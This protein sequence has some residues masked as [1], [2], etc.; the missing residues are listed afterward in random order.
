MSAKRV[1]N[2]ILPRMSQNALYSGLYLVESNQLVATEPYRDLLVTEHALR[3]YFVLAGTGVFRRDSDQFPVK[4]NDVFIQDKG[5]VLHF[6]T[7]GRSPLNLCWIDLCGES[8][9]ALV[10]L[11]GVTEAAPLISG[12]SA[13]RFAREMSALVKDYDNLSA[14]DG[15]EILSHLYRLFSI[16]L[17]ASDT[18]SQWQKTPHTHWD[19]LYTGAWKYWPSP[20]TT[21]PEESYTAEAKAYVEYNF[22]GT[23]IKW[24]G[25]MNFDCGK[26]DVIIDGHYQTTIDCYSPERLSH[27]LLYIN[28]KLP[29]GPHIIKIFCTG[30]KNPKATNVDVVVES[31]QCY[32]PQPPEAVA[33]HAPLPENKTS[34]LSRQVANYIRDHY[35]QELSVQGIADI[36]GLNRSY[37]TSRFTLENGISPSK[38]LSQIRMEKA[39]EYLLT[40][41]LTISAIAEAVGFQDVF[42]FSRLFKKHKKMSPS[43]Y[44]QE[45]R[46]S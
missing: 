30:E 3:L 15:M 31:F 8:V 44:R 34:L 17:D 24:Y 4:Q 38:Y 19:L 21:S 1:S 26:A 29:D 18:T 20:D 43:C 13:P 42:Y 37:M 32:C 11:L 28:T 2:E 39:S 36:L 22:S 35:R 7:N 46:I 14:A 27:Q 40:T 23:G 25:T 5:S 9:P 41:D 12:L 45:K 16:L 10:R 33:E 6:H